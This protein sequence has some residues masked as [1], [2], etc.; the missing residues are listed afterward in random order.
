[1]AAMTT[2]SVP[3]QGLRF[4]TLLGAVSASDDCEAGAGVYLIVKNGNA[5]A[6]TV[7]ITA[8]ELID[9]DLTVGSRVVSVPATVGY[10]IIPVTQRYRSAS[11]GRAT[12]TFSPT[13][14]V[15]AC[16]VKTAVQ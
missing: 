14:T 9:G 4:D 16:I 11:T 12:V 8:P 2:N 5:G 7:T 10:T 6:C 13:A 1:L 15:T 3:L